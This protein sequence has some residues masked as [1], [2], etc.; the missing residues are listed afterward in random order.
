MTDELSTEALEQKQVYASLDEA[1]RQRWSDLY[2]TLQVFTEAELQEIKTI[3]K[4]YWFETYEGNK[5]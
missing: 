2:E 3:Q 1:G 5:E 4:T